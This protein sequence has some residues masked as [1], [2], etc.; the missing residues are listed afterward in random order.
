MEEGQRRRLEVVK[1]VEVNQVVLK[2]KL[3]IQHI[4]DICMI[5]MVR[6]VKIHQM[7]R[8]MLVVI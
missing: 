7:V 4:V 8:I 2:L 3:M 5:V 6:Y 1:G